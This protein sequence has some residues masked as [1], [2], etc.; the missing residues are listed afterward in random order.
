MR[1]AGNIAVAGRLAA[2]RDQDRPRR[3]ARARPRACTA[4]GPSSVARVGKISAPLALENALVDLLDAVDLAILVGDQRRPV[5]ADALGR[6]AEATRILKIV[7]EPRR[8]NEELFRH[9]AADHAGAAEA[10][11]FRDAHLCP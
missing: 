7:P 9:A 3:D 6:P 8:I 11:A 5:E 1:R 10:V 4:P 2:R